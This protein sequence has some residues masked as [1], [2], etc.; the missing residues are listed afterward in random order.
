MGR[1]HDA[2][3]KAE[4]ERARRRSEASGGP[5]SGGA[6]SSD[7]AR[8]PKAPRSSTPPAR[9]EPVRRAATSPPRSEEKKAAPA[10]RVARVLNRVT[11]SVPTMGSVTPFADA[12]LSW[13]SPADFRSE[14]FRSIRTNLSVLDP[15]P[16]ILAL[17]SAVPHEGVAVVTANLAVCF[18]EGGSENVLIVDANLRS[19]EVESIFGLAR[20][21]PG[22][23]QVLADRALPEE[24][25]RPTGIDGLSI[26]SAGPAVAN[27]GGLI[28]GLRVARALSTWRSAFDRV[29]IVTPPVSVASDASVVG[30][31][32]DGVLFVVKLG[33]TP[34][35]MTER[36]IDSLG[37]TGVRLVGCVLTNAD[38]SD[39]LDSV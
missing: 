8:T 3:K 12:L 28:T 4:R 34:R 31:E 24:V 32:A 39:A 10:G 21:N 36:A 18:A 38:R 11:E 35:R 7:V 33:A 37:M 13:H 6:S 22:L 9:P 5:E 20:D 26:V 15:S 2:L 14:Q 27:P 29:L 19:P 23:S 17:T 16:E 30:H 1:I 25:V